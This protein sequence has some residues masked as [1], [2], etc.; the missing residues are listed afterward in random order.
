VPN[1][2]VYYHLDMARALAAGNKD[3]EAMHA[4]AKAERAAP[5]H[6]RFSSISR[7]LV[8][9]LVHRAKR[10]AVQGEMTHL[11]RKLG[12]DVVWQ[13]VIVRAPCVNTFS[14]SGAVLVVAATARASRPFHKGG[15][16]VA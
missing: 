12:I 13:P 1:R 14:V 3:I 11:A 16:R 5:Q 15:G 10:R 6:F 2:W 7:D 8:G 4:L 9:T